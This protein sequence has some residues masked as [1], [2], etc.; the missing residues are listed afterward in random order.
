MFFDLLWHQLFFC[1]V[2]T[3]FRENKL[4]SVNLKPVLAET[5]LHWSSSSPYPREQAYIGQQQARF[6]EIKLTSV[7]IGFVF[8]GTSLHRSTESMMLTKIYL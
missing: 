1:G 7:N 8:A 3:Q 4:T 2:Q 5:S 6:R